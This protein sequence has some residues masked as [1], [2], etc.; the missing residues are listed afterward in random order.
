MTAFLKI[1][2]ILTSKERKGAL[3]NLALMF[4]GMA[5]ETLGVGVV[6]PLIALLA[7]GDLA[8]LYPQLAPFL[9]WM[10]NPTQAELIR[11]AILALVVVYVVRS[12]FLGFQV[13][14]QT[15]YAADVRVALAQRLFAKYLRQPYTFH[16]QR[17]SAQ[18][19]RNVSG[20]VGIFGALITQA[21]TLVAEGLV[22]VGVVWL[23][24][25]VEPVG[26]IIVGLVIG[27]AGL[28]FHYGTRSRVARWGVARQLHEGL[29]FQHLQQG[30]GGAKDV[31]LLGRDEDFLRE[32]GVHGA[33]SARAAQLA[34]TLAA[35]PRLWLELLAVI[36][37]AILVL[38]MLAQGRDMATVMPTLGLFAAGAF[39]LM[40]SVNRLL[41]AVQYLRFGRPV[42]DV[43]H[44]ELRLPDP[45][46][47]PTASGPLQ[48][49]REIR[50]ADVG[51]A[52]PS[53]P[54]PALKGVTLSIQKGESVGFIG[55]TG[56]GK[57]TLV[58]V[59]LGLLPPTTGKVLVDDLD[60]QENLRGWQDQ[61]GYVPQSIYLTDD[62]IRR[63]V[64]FGLASTEIDDDAVKR[65]LEAAQLD[66]FVATLPK[67]ME[68]VVGER[69][70]RLSG[71]QRQRI[72]IARALYHQPSILVF[73]EATSALDTETEREVMNALVALRGEKTILIVAHRLST[74]EHCDRLYRVVMG[75]VTQEG[76]PT[77]LLRVPQVG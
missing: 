9:R 26:A 23:L 27:G 2:D 47:V 44:E 37:L 62:S 46:S 63:N 67:G 34:G 24:L 60:I 1:R 10:G 13:W 12:L 8:A 22:L 15:K 14:C 40:P 69:G 4:V 59:V 49:R 43:L 28:A 45:P 53:A 66:R 18:L 70:V 5:L 33:H 57:S 61:I 51:F 32:H 39:R 31:K 65:A 77:E 48:F 56:S 16:L 6:V 7:E 11:T 64:A 3:I 41:A 29:R 74:V 76:R 50:L 19:M 20:E 35:L 25:V 17:N 30:L 68:T 72:G 36:G 52:Y 42:I 54:A 75:R 38:T 71:G 55:P 21:M 73:D 58:D